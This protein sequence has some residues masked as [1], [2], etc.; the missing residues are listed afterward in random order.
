[1]VSIHRSSENESERRDNMNS[2]VYEIMKVLSGSQQYLRSVGKLALTQPVKQDENRTVKDT[3]GRGGWHWGV[4][5]PTSKPEILLTCRDNK[6][7]DAETDS[8]DWTSFVVCVYRAYRFELLNNPFE[9]RLPRKLYDELV[10]AGV[11]RANADLSKTVLVDLRNLPMFPKRDFDEEY[12][13]D[14]ISLL[15]MRAK[16]EE[17][18]YLKQQ[19]VKYA[20]KHELAWAPAKQSRTEHPDWVTVATPYTAYAVEVLGAEISGGVDSTLYRTKEGRS[21]VYSEQNFKDLVEAIETTDAVCKDL[22]EKVRLVELSVLEHSGAMVPVKIGEYTIRPSLTPATSEN[23]CCEE[24]AEKFVARNPSSYICKRP[25]PT[26][27][28]V[29]QPQPVE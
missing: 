29:E 3:F 25:V 27:A 14:K 21:F 9:A 12:M 23:R 11:C 10:S 2:N 13:E 24:D 19:A 16:L 5:L 20:R 15:G 8:F 6:T 22:Q 4:S 7:H 26:V 1:M 17:L 18:R 28:E